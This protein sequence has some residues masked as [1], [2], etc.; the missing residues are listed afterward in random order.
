MAQPEIDRL[1]QPPA[2]LLDIDPSGAGLWF[3]ALWSELRRIRSSVGLSQSGTVTTTD[4]TKTDV[5]E[6]LLNP[7]RGYHFVLRVVFYDYSNVVGGRIT[8]TGHGICGSGVGAGSYAIVHDSTVDTNQTDVP[9]AET[10]GI[11]VVATTQKIKVTVTGHAATTYE[12]FADLRAIAR[13]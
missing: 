13:R 8:V 11:E 2:A 9:N 6:M 12:W 5:F 1:S 4:A 10:S 7:G 3:M